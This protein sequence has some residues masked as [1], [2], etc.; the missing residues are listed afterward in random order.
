MSFAD[1]LIYLRQYYGAT[2]ETMA[3]QLGVSRQTVSKWESGINFPETDKL[4]LLC[5]LYHTNLDDLMLGSV[6]ITNEQDTKAY[7][8]H[9]N[10]FSL[11]IAAL[12]FGFLMGVGLFILLQTRGVAANVCAVI[13]LCFIVLAAVIGIVSG[14]NHK[15]FKRKNAF[16]EPSYPKEV[17]DRFGKRFTMMI[18]GG[19][20]LIFVGIIALVGFSPAEGDYLTLAGTILNYEVIIALFM[21]LLALATGL[22]SFAGM[23]KSKYNMSEVSQRSADGTI[24]RSREGKGIWAQ[25][26]AKS[27][28]ELRRDNLVGSLCGI[29][30]ILSVVA[31]FVIGFTGETAAE[32]SSWRD[33]GLGYSWIALVVGILLCAIT[34]LAVGAFTKTDRELMAECQKDISRFKPEPEAS[35]ASDVLIGMQEDCD[36]GSPR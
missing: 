7:D 2:Q 19:L 3:E 30:M 13:L 35:E 9:M 16:I 15:E 34:T 25:A 12:P 11:G 4:L 27:V 21:F 23:Q 6:H 10:R 8:A 24:V 17:H 1:N 22:L 5:N 26:E 28:E 20:G 36:T 29:I 18:A 32:G 33:G 31:F 14:M